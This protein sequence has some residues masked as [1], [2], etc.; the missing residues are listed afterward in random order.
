M[1]VAISVSCAYC[2]ALLPLVR[3]FPNIE[4]NALRARSLKASTGTGAPAVATLVD[5]D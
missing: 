2:A 5:G 4:S 3:N 1:A